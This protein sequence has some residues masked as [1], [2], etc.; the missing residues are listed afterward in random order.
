MTPINI[1]FI[2]STLIFGITNATNHLCASVCVCEEDT[3]S[4]KLD[5]SR[6]YLSIVPPMEHWPWNI[7]H[8]D[9]SFNN[10]TALD[11]ELSHNTIEVLDLSHNRIKYLAQ[12][13]F[14]GLG[15]LKYLNLAGNDIQQFDE[16]GFFGLEHLKSL[17]VSS[18]GLSFLPD[19]LFYFFIGLQELSLADNPLVHVDPIHFN[20][21][22]NLRWLDMSSIGVYSLQ[23]N[24]FHPAG[25]LE[26]LDLSSNDFHE[27]PT[28]A[29]RSAKMLNHLRLSENPLDVLDK[30][31]FRKLSTLEVLELNSMDFL[32][33]VE[34]GTF[35][36]LTSLRVLEMNYNRFLSSIH[37]LA[38]HGLF[39][40]SRPTLQELDLEGNFLNFL[41]Q[42]MV[43]CAKMRK[44]NVQRNPWYCDCNLRWIKECD[45]QKV[46]AAD[47]KCHLPRKLT[48]A[49]IVD[50]NESDF[51]CPQYGDTQQAE[52]AHHHEVVVRSMSIGL[53]AGLLVIIAFGIAVIFKW[54][55][56]KT[57]YRR[58]RRG[59]GAV[60][61]VKARANPREI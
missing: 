42:F 33:T 45:I 37:P 20:R 29:L 13:A 60:Y 35:S 55:A 44:F 46:Y 50:L 48:D 1:V 58:E 24:I 8:M 59:P 56:V 5:C 36:D 2:I 16:N 51:E 19:R 52:S 3:H 23:P 27:V 10:I 9:L 30:K 32:K 7:T 41:D 43:P 11:Y 53:A 38:F 12:N 4:V 22:I 21:M 6:V 25:Q 17:N 34:E 61:Y 54:K 49:L 39:N 18:N 15:H 57:W 40:Q 26:F 47:L 31:A 14:G 28:D